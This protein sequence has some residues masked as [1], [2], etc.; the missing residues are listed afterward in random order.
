[1]N[2]MPDV[3]KEI[4]ALVLALAVLLVAFALAFPTTHP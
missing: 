3:A 4:L 2:R 1:M